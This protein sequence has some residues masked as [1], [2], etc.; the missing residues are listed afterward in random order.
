MEYS[1]DEDF[2][3]SQFSTREF[4]ETQ[5]AGY[6]DDVIEGVNNVVSL[7]GNSEN[8]CCGISEFEVRACSSGGESVH[9]GIAIEDITD[10]ENEAKM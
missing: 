3:L 5:S 10:D 6:G 9:D 7:E 4:Q 8:D 2:V 1:D